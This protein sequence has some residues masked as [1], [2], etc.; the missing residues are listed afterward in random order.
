MSD[1]Y[2]ILGVDRGAGEDALRDA[3]RKLAR[4]NHPD[5]R[6]DDPAALAGAL[7]RLARDPA[8]RRRMGARGRARAES[9]FDAR[10]NVA[11]L[12]GWMEE[13]VRSS[14]RSRRDAR[15]LPMRGPA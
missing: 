2:A 14:D 8:L 5:V 4:E 9:L 15:V 3:Y 13:A 1:L 6:P 10:T 12:H 11:R 7:G